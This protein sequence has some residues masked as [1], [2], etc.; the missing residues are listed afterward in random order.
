VI[1]YN[2]ERD[3]PFSRQGGVVGHFHQL[4]TKFF[5]ECLSFCRFEES[6]FQLAFATKFISPL[7]SF[8]QFSFESFHVFRDSLEFYSCF[9]VVWREIARLQLKL[10]FHIFPS[11]KS[12]SSWFVF[13]FEILLFFVLFYLK[14]WW[15]VWSEC[16]LSFNF[17]RSSQL[18]LNERVFFSSKVF[19]V[20]LYFCSDL[21]KS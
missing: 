11:I 19:W 16:V 17:E 10:Q 21:L 14:F 1:I 5:E 4:F 15:K 18:K 7:F 3:R 9:F 8:Y 20:K 13:L 12:Q 6:A 2:G